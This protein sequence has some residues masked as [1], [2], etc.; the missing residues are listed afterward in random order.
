MIFKNSLSSVIDELVINTDVS[1]C[2]LYGFF[3]L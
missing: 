1:A 2:P 3:D